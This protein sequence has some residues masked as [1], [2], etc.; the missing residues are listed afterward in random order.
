MGTTQVIMGTTMGVYVRKERRANSHT[1]YWLVTS[2]RVDGK[3]RQEKLKYMGIEKPT[4]DEVEAAKAE[5][6]P[7]LAARERPRRRKDGRPGK[8][9]SQD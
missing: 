4:S 1:Y 5:A 2:Y 7:K 3:V 6:W 8:L 9:S